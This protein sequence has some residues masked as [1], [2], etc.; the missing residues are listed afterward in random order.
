MLVEPGLRQRVED[1]PWGIGLRAQPL[2]VDA[3]GAQLRVVGERAELELLAARLLEERRGLGRRELAG[4][5]GVRQV[6]PEA[7]AVMQEELRAA[8]VRPV[9]AAAEERVPR[10]L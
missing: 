8:Q 2:P 10:P 3:K 1:Q 6:V 9:V 4:A 7:E 5:V